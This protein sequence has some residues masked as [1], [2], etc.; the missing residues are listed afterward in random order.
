VLRRVNWVARAAGYIWVGVLAFALFRADGLYATIALAIGY[1]V[2]GLALFA[3]AVL[4]VRPEL[5]GRYGLTIVLVAMA[6]SAGFGSAVAG[7]SI[8]FAAFGFVAA[9]LAGGDL[10][11]APALAVTAAGILATEV[12]G[13]L[14]SASAGTL[15]GVPAIVLSGMVVG[16]NRGAYRVQAEQSAALLAQRERLQAEQRRADLLDERARIA[17]EI[18]DVLAHSLGALGIQIQ[19]ARAVLADRRDVEQAGELLAGAQQLAAEGLVETRR[20]VQALRTDPPPLAEELAQVSDTYAQR[21]RVGVDYDTSGSPVP[22]P[23]DA[24]LALLR[25]AQEALVNAAKHAPRQ[26]VTIRLDY[27]DHDVRLTVRNAVSPGGVVSGLS[28]VNGGYGLTGM[29]ERI[30]LLNGTLD[31]G[32][33]DAEWVVTAELPR[34]GNIAS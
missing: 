19:A 16:R 34:P 7:G 3:W 22:L 5:G 32:R 21:Y 26:G 10:D 23:P 12:S 6:V 1:A 11:L 17:R 2:L 27:L 33:R 14:V 20:A 25:I 8:A 18:H 13:L 4:D 30:R 28:T 9:M 15:L 31:V 24:S 29:R